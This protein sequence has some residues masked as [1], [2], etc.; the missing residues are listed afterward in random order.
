MATSLA[1]FI[2]FLLKLRTFGPLT[3]RRLDAGPISGVR[4]T[5]IARHCVK[6]KPGA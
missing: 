3:I 2:D 1:L 6:A 5:P 4:L